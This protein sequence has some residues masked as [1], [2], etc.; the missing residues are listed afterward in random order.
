MK[1]NLEERH[2]LSYLNRLSSKEVGL[3]LWDKG[4]CGLVTRGSQSWRGT[5]GWASVTNTSHDDFYQHLTALPSGGYHPFC[6]VPFRLPHGNNFRASP[7]PIWP[8]LIRRGKWIKAYR[9]KIVWWQANTEMLQLQTKEVKYYQLSP[10]AGRQT[11][12]G[13]TLRRLPTPAF[14]LLGSRTVKQQLSVVW[15]HPVCGPFYSRSRKRIVFRRKPVSQKRR[16]PQT[17]SEALFLLLW[18]HNVL[19]GVKLLLLAW[20]SSFTKKKKKMFFTTAL[21]WRLMY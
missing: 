17:P 4:L 21:V 18:L 15:S 19:H 20:V 3:L 5:R 13:L 9:E 2:Y 7:N 1:K 14:G 10:E 16:D 11:W 6:L 8:V 12:N